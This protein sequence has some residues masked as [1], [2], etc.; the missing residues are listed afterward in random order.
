MA[1][2][3]KQFEQQKQA[4][5][6]EKQY[7]WQID[8][9]VNNIKAECNMEHGKEMDAWLMKMVHELNVIYFTSY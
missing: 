5:P 8:Q 2:P 6:E 9:K 3:Q 7:H 1:D 4:L